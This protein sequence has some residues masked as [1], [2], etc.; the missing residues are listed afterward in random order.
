MATGSGIDAV[1]RPD[2]GAGDEIVVVTVGEQPDVRVLGDPCRSDRVRA[3]GDADGEFPHAVRC[4]ARGEPCVSPRV[5]ARLDAPHRAVGMD[6]LS[7]RETEVP[8]PIASASRREISPEATPLN[9]RGGLALSGGYTAASG[10]ANARSLFAA[11]SRGTWARRRGRGRLKE[12]ASARAPQELFIAERG[13][14]RGLRD[15]PGGRREL[16][17]RCRSATRR[18]LAA[19]RRRRRR[20]GRLARRPPRRVGDRRPPVRGL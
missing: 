17:V 18:R 16:L 12:P 9:S 19:L 2:G 10:S 3:E 5:V 11:R 13:W 1:G 6:D 14:S 4:A 15:L 7:P 20:H 8:R